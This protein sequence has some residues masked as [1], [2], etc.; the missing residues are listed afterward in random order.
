MKPHIPN[1]R[2]RR[3]YWQRPGRARAYTLQ[4]LGNF[5]LSILTT[6]TFTKTPHSRIAI[7]FILLP[8]LLLVLS[9][10]LPLCQLQRPLVPQ[11]GVLMVGPVGAKEPGL[12]QGTLYGPRLFHCQFLRESSFVRCPCACRLLRL[13]Q[14]VGCG[15]GSS[16][17]LVLLARRTRFLSHVRFVWQG[18]GIRDIL[19]SEAS[20]CVTGA[21]HRTLF[22][23][24]AGVAL[25][26]RCWN[27]G[28]HGWKCEV[29]L[30]V[31][32]RSRRSIWWMKGSKASFCETVVSWFLILD[33][34]MIPCGG[35]STDAS[36]S[37]SV[38]RE[39]LCRP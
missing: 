35:C 19:R 28:R 2:Q 22:I 8:W 15:F 29:L 5:R 11:R 32:L 9:R 10:F 23:C 18:W 4:R 27:V 1:R 3:Y 34:M 26:A 14:D 38:V 6:M 30:E 25:S 39:V 17:G 20:F 31:I 7:L 16:E 24:V 21:G 13:A 36:G 12:G 33:M 37:F